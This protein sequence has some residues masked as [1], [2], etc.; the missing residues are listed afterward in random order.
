MIKIDQ[1]AC[2]GLSKLDSLSY[3]S[4]LGQSGQVG[5]ILSTT[6][7]AMASGKSSLFEI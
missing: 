4:V 3:L 7:L 5:P 2:L 1:L 6:G